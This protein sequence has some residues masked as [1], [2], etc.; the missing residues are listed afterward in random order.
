MHCIDADDGWMWFY[1][2][3]EKQSVTP[4]KMYNNMN[5]HRA[6]SWMKTYMYV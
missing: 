3:Q 6:G 4:I 1:V 5:G 2:L